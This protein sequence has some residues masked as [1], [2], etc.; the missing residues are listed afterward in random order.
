MRDSTKF[1]LLSFSLLLLIQPGFNA[2]QQYQV[3][4]G[5]STI[6]ELPKHNIE[7]PKS[8][9]VPIKKE[10]LFTE[11]PTISAEST[12]VIDKESAAILFSQNPD[13]QLY[14]A[15]ITKVM[16]AL[17]AL[18]KLNLDQ[19]VT[20]SEESQ[21]VGNT[22]HLQ[23]GEQITVGELMK[24]LLI[25]S[26]NDAAYALATAYPGGYYKFVE[27]KNE[28]A[29]ELHMENTHFVSV[30]GVEE[31]GHVTT[32]RDIATLVKEAM[33]NQLFAETV[34]IKQA[35]ISDISGT[36]AH[37]LYSTNKLL[38]TVQGVEGIK[39]GW[40]T[41]A[42]E[43]LVTQTTRDGHTLITVVLNS[44]DR[45]GDSRRLIEWIFA[46]HEWRYF[47]FED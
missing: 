9:I 2:V 31:E 11:I 24:G 22:I 15:S 32:A 21:A 7:I 20:I 4:M 25:A 13:K 8:A 30:S 27:R 29:K 36:I 3:T 42:G 1:S 40:T 19:I 14:P 44:Q 38:G 17:V 26:G 46:M 45:F 5:E 43:C 47:L 39:T 28:K 34:K 41:Q 10:N 23:D 12:I 6:A 37:Q 18:E 33:K 16:T 35:S